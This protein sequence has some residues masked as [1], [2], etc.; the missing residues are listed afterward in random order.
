MLPGW[1]SLAE[2][3][4]LFDGDD[5]Y[6]QT[7]VESFHRWAEKWVEQS[8]RVGD[9]GIDQAGVTRYQWQAE[10]LE[11]PELAARL[12]S[13]LPPAVRTELAQAGEVQALEQLL[14]S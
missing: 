14:A 3:V 5:Q 6:R 1:R 13:V 4:L 2:S 8:Q 11:D 12:L 9:I 7:C 10:A